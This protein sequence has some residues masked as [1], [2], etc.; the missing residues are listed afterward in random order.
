M[1]RQ[2]EYR[3][4]LGCECSYDL[5]SSQ[6]SG[7]YDKWKWFDYCLYEAITRLSL[8][9]R[10]RYPVYSGLNGVKLDTKVVTR[11]FF[12]TYVSASWKKE[13]SKAFMKDKGMLIEIDEEYR[14]TRWIY[15]CDVSWISKFPDEC[16]VLFARASLR[17]G[18]D[19]SCEILDEV[20]GIQIVSLKKEGKDPTSS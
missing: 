12:V 5:C 7:D 20:N 9:E 17:R 2:N 8:K 4:Y 6:R 15:C 16:E 11:G 18:N 10:G 19:F 14:D 13:V 1:V 3:L